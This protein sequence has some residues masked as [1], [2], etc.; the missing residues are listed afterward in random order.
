MWSPLSF[1]KAYGFEILVGAAILFIL[2]VAFMRIGK[3]GTWNTPWLFKSGTYNKRRPPTESRG[4]LECKKVLED[5]FHRPFNKVRMD[6]MKNPITNANLE[7]DCY[8]DDLKLAVEYHGKQHYEYSHFLHGGNK[9]R[10]RNQQYRDYVKKDLCQKNGIS[11][12][13]V[14]YTVT[15]DKIKNFLANQLRLLG[16]R[17]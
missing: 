15:I 13:E 8:N 6:H 16:Y 2:F 17:I 5:F 4:E 12:I 14:P 1:W 3:K 11:L 9:E 7:L 10:F